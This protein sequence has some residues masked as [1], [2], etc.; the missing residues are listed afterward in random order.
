MKQLKLF[1]RAIF[2]KTYLPKLRE[3][4]DFIRGLFYLGNRFICPV[5]GGNFRKFLDFGPASQPN[6]QCPR[7]LSLK[8]HRLLWFYLKDKTN[9]FDD[10]FKVL[11]MAPEYCFYQRFSKQ[12]NLDYISADIQSPLAQVKMDITNIVYED[13]FF[14]VILCN[15]V[16]EHIPD[17]GKAMKEL[18]RVLKPGGWAIMQVPIDI[19]RQ[20]TYENPSIESPEERKRL[21]G[22]EDHVRWYGLDYKDRLEL[23]G[24]AV[25]VD[26]YVKELGND[27]IKK[28]SLR[29]TENIYFCTKH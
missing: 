14:D 3:F 18:W 22:Q 1:I 8:R 13:N 23:A 29:E 19:N 16:L 27:V 6:E 25:K 26:S 5:C 4:R 12:K 20:Q 11:H 24:F 2:P 9:F 17:D 10:N 28:Y 21:F 15:H 7:C